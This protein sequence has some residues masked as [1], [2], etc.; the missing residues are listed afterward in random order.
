MVAHVAAETYSF[1]AFGMTIAGDTENSSCIARFA[2][3]ALVRA[4]IDPRGSE[5]SFLASRSGSSVI[6][7]CRRGVW[8]DLGYFIRE[9]SYP[10]G[11]DDRS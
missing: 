8:E 9:V 3:R 4:H 2:I 5:S 11:C 10:S 7:P 1:V 6:R